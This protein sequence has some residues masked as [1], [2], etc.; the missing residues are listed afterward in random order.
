MTYTSKGTVRVEFGVANDDRLAAELLFVP[1]GDYSIK[2]GKK[3]FAVFV[4]RSGQP[5]FREY[6][7]DKEIRIKTTQVPP[8]D[9]METKVEIQVK[10]L[11]NAAVAAAEAAA[12]VATTDAMREAI[13]NWRN[14]V[15][16]GDEAAATEVVK[17]WKKREE[18]TEK[19]EKAMR[20]GAVELELIRITTPTK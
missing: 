3:T 14:A 13:T 4:P 18:A 11:R 9:C 6:S 15:A 2:H 16:F 17:R 7:Q 8:Y 1:D 20:D 5:I 12:V 10:E 19:A